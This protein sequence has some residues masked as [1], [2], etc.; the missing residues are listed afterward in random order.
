MAVIWWARDR[1]GR[2]VD[3]TEAAWAH[4]MER[5]G[6]A[7]FDRERD[8]RQAV[9]QADLV[10]DDADRADRECHYRRLQPHRPMLKVVVEYRA[11]PAE[12]APTGVVITAYPTE[13]EKPRE[14]RRWR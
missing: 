13:N 9:E 10:N 2:E 14:V 8:V 1:L 4:S 11:R 7:M 12:D 5:H 3:L 6:Q